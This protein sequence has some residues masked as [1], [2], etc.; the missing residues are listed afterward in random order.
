[1]EINLAHK[2]LINKMSSIFALMRELTVVFSDYGPVPILSMSY[3]SID[4]WLTKTV[5]V[6]TVCE[7]EEL[8]F[9][10][11]SAVCLLIEPFSRILNTSLLSRT[12]TS[13]RP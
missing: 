9:I 13:S 3:P 4:C 8:A 2:K 6:N 11:V 12:W 7:R 1:M 5:T 10:L